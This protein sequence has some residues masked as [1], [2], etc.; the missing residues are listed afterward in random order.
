M[1]FE[2]YLEYVCKK[3]FLINTYVYFINA[4]PFQLCHMLSMHISAFLNKKKQNIYLDIV[5][6]FCFF[7]PLVPS[8]KHKLLNKTLHFYTHT[9]QYTGHDEKIIFVFTTRIC[10]F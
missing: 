7:T 5:I 10:H 2:I 4:P 9:H 6:K 8:V 1:L 3:F